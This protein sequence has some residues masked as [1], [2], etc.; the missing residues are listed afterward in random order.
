LCGDFER[1]LCFRFAL[2]SFLHLSVIWN[3]EVKTYSRE[4]FFCTKEVAFAG[5]LK[6]NP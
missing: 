1:A 5:G 2:I 3:L 6:I 4:I